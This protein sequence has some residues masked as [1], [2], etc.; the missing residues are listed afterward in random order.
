L[1]GLDHGGQTPGVDLLVECVLQTWEAFAVFIDGADVFWKDAGLR[2]WGTNAL[3]EPPQV[4]RAPIG[5]AGVTAIVSEQKGFEATLGVLAI[6]EGI[7]TGPREIPN[8]GIFPLR[9]L[10]DGEVPRARQAGEGHGISAVGFD[11]IAGFWGEQRGCDHPAIIAFFHPI[12][13]APGAPGTRF[14]DT[15]Q[16]G[17]L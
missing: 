5:P 1:Q 13:I 10:H 3:R 2:R 12:P 7:C 4:G 6:A 16:M 17:G 11:A 14:I 15:E 8:G 9:D